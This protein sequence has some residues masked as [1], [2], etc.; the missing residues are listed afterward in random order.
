MTGSRVGDTGGGLFSGGRA[1]LGLALVLM[2][3]LVAFEGL[4]VTAALP[5]IGA[6]LG[7]VELLPWVITV[8]LLASGVAIA[9]AGPV[10]D[11][12]GPRTVFRFATLAFVASS[13]LCGVAQEMVW[14]VAARVLQGLA[15]GTVMSTTGS[16]IGLGYPDRLRSRAYALTSTV[17]GV[18]AFGGPALAAL[19]LVHFDWRMIFLANVP[20]A[21]VAAGVGWWGVPGPPGSPRRPVLDAPG[22]LL[23]LGI[24]TL[25]LTA[26]SDLGLRGLGALALALVFGGGYWRYSRGREGLVL[27]R[28]YFAQHPFFGLAAAAALT[29]S[30]GIGAETYL[31]L[32]LR[33][34]RGASV[35]EAAWSVLYLTVGWTVAANV[36]S[37]LYHRIDEWRMVGVGAALLLPSLSAALGIV[38]FEGSLVALYAAYF[39]VGLGIGATTNACLTLVQACARPEEIGRATTAHQFLRNVAVTWG[40]ALAGALTLAWVSVR[41]VDPDT[42]RETL[43]GVGPGRV[44]EMVRRSLAVGFAAAHAVAL[45]IAVGA[46]VS[47]ARVRR[48]PK[49][50][51]VEET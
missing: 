3:G 38:W 25:G 11:A 43:E 39:V 41:G 36:A 47:A 48:D 13:Y 49:P 35:T 42:L 21:M 32:Y 45:V 33:G 23:L 7:D 9:M 5:E 10:I 14:L 20:L 22:S 31:P 37:R 2:S 24:V 16:A 40:A 30:A 51:A 18:L 50:V 6:A 15:G 12:V 17:W 34:A 26:A 28:R 19:L 27:Q 8:Y 4:S 1:P 44:D 29:M 46:C